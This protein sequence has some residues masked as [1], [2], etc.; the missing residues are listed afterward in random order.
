M[1]L[2]RSFADPSITI[3]L[4]GDDVTKTGIEFREGTDLSDVVVEVGPAGGTVRKT[5]PGQRAEAEGS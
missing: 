1:H 4:N 5:V 3:K 2:A